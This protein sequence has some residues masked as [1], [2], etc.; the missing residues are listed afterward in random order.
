[1]QPSQTKPETLRQPA[2]DIDPVFIQRWSPRSFANKDVPEETLFSLFEAAR[3]APSAN[4]MQPWRFIVA[5]TKEDLETFHSFILPGN[6]AWCQ[7]A[8][9]LAVLASATTTERGDNRAHAFDAGTAWGYLALEAT[10]QGLVTHAMGG[11]DREKA[12]AALGLPD[13]VEPQIVI[14]IGYRGE[15]EAL[16]ENLQER[17]QPNGRRPLNETVFEGGFGKVIDALK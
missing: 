11:F 8:P 14:A 13:D 17:E 15:K 4:N 1:M 16:P 7:N 3:W 6:L 9:A 2:Y 5:R 10:R 12:R